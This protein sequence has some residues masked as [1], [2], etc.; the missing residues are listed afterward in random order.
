MAIQPPAAPLQRKPRAAGE[1][2]IDSADRYRLLIDAIT[3]YA[4]YMLDPDGY[5]SSWNPGAERI[6][7]YKASEIIGEHFSRFYTDEERDAGVPEHALATAAAEGRFEREG[8]RVR[9]DGSRFWAHVIIDAIRG[10]GGELVGFAKITRDLTERRATEE[11]LRRSEEQ[12]RLLVQGV[13]DYAIYMLDR[14]GRVTSWNAGAERI[15]GYR[16]REIVGQHFSRFYT[17]EDRRSGLPQRGLE[18]A[19]RV[20][21]FEM[22]GWRVRKDGTPF[23][24]HVIIDAIRD[25]QGEII[26]FAKITRDITERL[27]ANQALDQAR[28]AL[29]QA[30]KMEAVG[31]LTGGV[32][33][34]F[35][36]LLM[37]ILGSLELLRKRLPDDPTITHLV[38]NAIQGAERGATL[39]QR[40]LAFARRQ[41]LKLDA[42]DVPTLVTEMIGLLERSTGPQIRLHTSFAPALPL[43]RT[44]PNQLEAALLNLTL[45]ARDAMAGSG[46]ITIEAHVEDSSAEPGLDLKPGR[47]VRLRV[48]DSGEGMDEETLARATEPF[49]TTKGV[50]KGTGLGLSMVHGLAQQSGGAL[51]LKSTK[52]HGASVEIW[53]PIADE[54]SPRAPAND[55]VESPAEVPAL[56][57]LAVDDDELVLINTVAMLEDLGHSVLAAGSGQEALAILAQHPEIELVLTDYAMPRMSGLQLIRQVAQQRPEAAAILA[58]GYAEIPEGEAE[59]LPRLAKPFNQADLGRA[60]ASAWR[61]GVAA[62]GGRG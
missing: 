41:E 3:D 28:E 33:H 24:A 34:D 21:R 51:R 61:G 37:A 36:N 60:I 46:V 7:G 5:V 55:A 52:G 14:S 49:F 19:A 16:A 39:T 11:A 18:T 48:I 38:N 31:Q 53:L 62:P 22:E 57:I 2:P 54:R 17:E 6:K 8:W 43:A 9:K 44:D 45:N 1:N 23:W 26:G 56:N 42:V 40:M 4:I 27:E 50:G 13:T 10:P 58:T 12:F 15:K 30:Q 59:G 47:Y 32:A 20:G 35:N 29:F 25:D